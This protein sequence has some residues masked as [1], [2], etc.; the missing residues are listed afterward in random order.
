M[1]KVVKSCNGLLET[2]MEQNKKGYVFVEY[3]VKCHSFTRKI[4]GYKHK[5]YSTF[6]INYKIKKTINKNY[7]VITLHN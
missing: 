1:K 5:K 3:S 6:K 2:A 4:Q 7:Y